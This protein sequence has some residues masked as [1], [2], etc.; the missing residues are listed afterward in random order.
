[1]GIEKIN[2]A[3]KF[4]LFSEHWSPKIVGDLNQ[5]QVKLAKLKGDF[6]M[7]KHDNEDELFLVIEGTLFIELEEKTL[8]LNAGEFVIIPKGVNHKPYAPEKVKVLLFEPASTLNTGEVTN[9]LTKNNLDRL[10][11]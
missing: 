2:I 8:E 5:Q 3:D 1:M 7:H 10:D 11:K 4:S 6:V 9:H